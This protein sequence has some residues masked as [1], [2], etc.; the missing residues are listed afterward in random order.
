MERTEAFVGY[1]VR[2]IV[3]E[4]C[5]LSNDVSSSNRRRYELWY[6]CSFKGHRL[7]ADN[8][9]HLELL[10]S[11]LSGP[12]RI[13]SL[14]WFDKQILVNLP[15]WMILAKNRAGVLRCLREMYES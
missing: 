7:W 8:R 15:K 12:R 11:W 2:C 5:G 1:G 14:D 3:C 9:R 4:H 10:I 13:S 6:A